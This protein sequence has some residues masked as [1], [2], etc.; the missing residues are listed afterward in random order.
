MN[1]IGIEGAKEGLYA[2]DSGPNRR[3]FHFA[4]FGVNEGDEGGKERRAM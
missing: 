4:C 3:D 2:G 1:R